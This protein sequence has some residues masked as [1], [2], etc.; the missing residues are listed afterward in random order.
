MRAA[1]L[2]IEFTVIGFDDGRPVLLRPG[3]IPREEIE[4]IAAALPTRQ[5]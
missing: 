5:A 4:D 1:P 2:G 3:A